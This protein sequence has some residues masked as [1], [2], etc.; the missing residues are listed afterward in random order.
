[1]LTTKQIL[2]IP[3]GHQLY[4]AQEGWKGTYQEMLF[5]ESLKNFQQYRVNDILKD[6]DLDWRDPQTL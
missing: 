2:S 5:N 3:Y 4:S 6:E 1:M